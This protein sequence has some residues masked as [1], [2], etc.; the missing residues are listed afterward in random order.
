MGVFCLLCNQITPI[1]FWYF[2]GANAA[3]IASTLFWPLFLPI[4][5]IIFSICNGITTD[6]HYQYKK[7]K[8]EKLKRE[9]KEKLKQEQIT[10]EQRLKEE[11]LAEEIN[12]YKKL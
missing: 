4:L 6:Y 2:Y 11:Q 8:K 10:Q 5:F 12:R 3:A 7:Y 9:T 1:L